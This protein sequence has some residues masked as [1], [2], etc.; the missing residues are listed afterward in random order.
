MSAAAVP[1]EQSP[2]LLSV[3]TTSS[4]DAPA[5]APPL[6]RTW[7]RIV[8]LVGCTLACGVLSSFPALESLLINY[9]VWDDGCDGM[10]LGQCEAQNT[11][12]GNLYYVATGL[13]VGTFFLN[14]QL[15]DWFGPRDSAVLGAVGVIVSSF[16]LWLAVSF[17]SLSWLLWVGV[18]GADAFGY[19]TSWCLLGFMFHDAPR[20][21]V[22]IGLGNGSYTASS[23]VLTGLFALN[24]AYGVALPNLFLIQGALAFLAA[25]LCAVSL[26]G[27]AELWQQTRRVTG[28]VPVKAKF[29]PLHSIRDAFFL[30]RCNP[31]FNAWF[32]AAAIIP[33]VALVNYVGSS[34]A[35]LAIE[36]GDNQANSYGALFGLLLTIFGSVAAPPAGFVFEWLGMRN[37]LLLVAA[38]QAVMFLSSFVSVA[39]L[40]VYAAMI[41][42]D[43]I[44]AAWQMMLVKY[45]V[46]FAPAAVLGSFFGTIF[47]GAGLPQLAFNFAIPAIMAAAVPATSP[48]QYSI[49]FGVL[50]GLATLSLVGLAAMFTWRQPPKT[51]PECET[52]NTPLCGA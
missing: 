17:K 46:V 13:S 6:L 22:I 14:G 29:R 30:L 39:P 32:C 11:A 24:T 7:L 27:Q 8:A 40:S 45:A 35:F 25:V 42:C 19:L 52:V 26:P 36:L 41:S 2:L 33:Y 4:V 28:Q 23:A 44:L 3:N 15:Y 47:S 16:V 18:T 49:P 1:D 20:G 5:P 48:L 9:G 51:P 50:G 31:A 43:L 12:M 37:F 21:A 34:H 38:L 10:P